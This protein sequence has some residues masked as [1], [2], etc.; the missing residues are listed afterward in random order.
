MNK[1]LNCCLIIWI[2]QFIYCCYFEQVTSCFDNVHCTQTVEPMSSG[3]S[4]LS[5]VGTVNHVSV[6]G[7]SFILT[8]SRL[9][10]YLPSVFLPPD[11]KLISL[12]ECGLS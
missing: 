11:S 9:M 7:T 10:E 2:H 3:C 5:S 12:E 8:S 1:N 4:V 6:T